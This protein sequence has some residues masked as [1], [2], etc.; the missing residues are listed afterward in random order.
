MLWVK[1]VKS[2]KSEYGEGE[3]K[4]TGCALREEAISENRENRD[5]M[6]VFENLGYGIRTDVRI[7]VVRVNHVMN[8]VGGGGL[9]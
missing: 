2:V 9:E 5:I 1:R 8:K 4:W 7:I 6:C 3:L